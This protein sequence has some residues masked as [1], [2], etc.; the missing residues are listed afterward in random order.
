MELHRCEFGGFVVREV[1][2]AAGGRMPRH[3]HDFSNVTAV[4]S[5]EME[6][7]TDAAQHRGR[8]CSVLLK[9]AGTMHENVWLGR[10]GTRTVSVE[11]RGASPIVAWQWLEDPETARAALALIAAPGRDAIE[12][13][14]VA[15][16]ASATSAAS[17]ARGETPPWLGE[18]KAQ[19]ERD[20][21]EPL[22]FDAIAHDFGLHPVY[23][24][25]AFRRH[26][27]R[28]MGEY[29][30]ALRLRE[31]RHLLS[32]TVRPLATISA[33]TGFAD[34]SHLCRVFTQAHEVT[35]NAFRRL[36]QV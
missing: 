34:A 31:A 36:T 21:D 9:P 19:L 24:S 23:L 5:G 10:R 18:V 16:I 7:T 25:R 17:V 6:E 8:S 14:A 30:R 1:G 28:T 2:Y 15:L 3:A 27:G 33:E 11:F 12:T 32:A 22:R 13:A 26:T 29:V 4:I 20:F 35:P